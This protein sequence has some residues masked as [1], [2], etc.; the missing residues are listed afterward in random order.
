MLLLAP[1]PQTGGRALLG[2]WVPALPRRPGPC[3]ARTHTRSARP[4]TAGAKSCFQRPRPSPVLNPPGS[5]SRSAVNHV[6]DNRSQFHSIWFLPP[7]PRRQISASPLGCGWRPA[8]ELGPACPGGGWAHGGGDLATAHG[9]TEVARARGL[10]KT[11]GKSSG[12]SRGHHSGPPPPPGFRPL[13][14]PS[15]AKRQRPR[16]GHTQPAGP[17]ARG[18]SCLSPKSP[19]APPLPR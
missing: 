10:E 8:E 13:P 12:G 1:A 15:P 2:S 11:R 6:K 19:P 5:Q 14:T 7:P 4:V 17:K 9:R 18:A 3:P 16:R